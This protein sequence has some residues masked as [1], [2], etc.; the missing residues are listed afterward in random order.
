MNNERIVDISEKTK[1]VKQNARETETVQDEE[2]P[3]KI[4]VSIR[5]LVR[6]ASMKVILRR[7]GM[8]EICQMVPPRISRTE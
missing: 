4:E 6:V 2:M 1:R 7:N 3:I 8:T 5:K